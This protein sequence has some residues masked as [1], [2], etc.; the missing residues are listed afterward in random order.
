[1]S[2]LQDRR[3]KP[4]CELDR[5]LLAH[6]AV[7]LAN[8]TQQGFCDRPVL[9]HRPPMRTGH[10]ELHATL[11]AANDL[12]PYQLPANGCAQRADTGFP[13]AIIRTADIEGVIPHR[14]EILGVT[15]ALAFRLEIGR[16]WCRGRGGE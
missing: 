8:G 11:H 3:P 5:R 14:R 2:G 1:M 6:V 4:P 9:R 10:R 12:M 16:A 15:M 7:V 13:D